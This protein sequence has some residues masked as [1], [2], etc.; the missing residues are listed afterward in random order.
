MK[1]AKLPTFLELGEKYAD[2]FLTGKFTEE[3]IAKFPAIREVLYEC[4]RALVRT[5]LTEIEKLSPEEKTDLWN[6]CKPFC[7]KLNKEERIK[8]TQS[9]RALS[10]LVGKRVAT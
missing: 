5:G 9:Y 3:M 7:E 2:H 1:E 8:F 4:Y 10:S 6:E